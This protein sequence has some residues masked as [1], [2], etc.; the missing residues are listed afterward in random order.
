MEKLLEFIDDFSV[1][2]IMA[3]H[4]DCRSLGDIHSDFEHIADQAQQFGPDGQQEWATV[5][6]VCKAA[7]DLVEKTI[8]GEVDDVTA[9]MEAICQTVTSIKELI[10]CITQSQDGTAVSF[11]AELGI[12]APTTTPDNKSSDVSPDHDAFTDQAS[13][14]IQLPENVDED[15][16]K[17]FLANQP[18]VLETLESTILAAESDPSGDNCH[19]IKA[20]LHN[21]KGESGL[22][23]LEEMSSVCHEAESLLEDINGNFPGEGLFKAKDWLQNAVAV[24]T[25]SIFG[26][27]S[28]QAEQ[29]N[30]NTINT[31][32]DNNESEAPNTTPL[33]ESAGDGPVIAESDVPLVIDFVA[34]SN[35]HL[36]ATEAHL[37]SLEDDAGNKETINAIFRA[38]HTI[39]GVAGFLNLKEIG[40]LSHS[41][42]NLLDLARKDELE[43]TGGCI[44][45][46]FEASDATKQMLS[47]I[48][49]AVENHHPVKKQ[50]NLAEL[51]N[52][53]KTCASGEAPLSRLGQI[54]VENEVASRKNIRDALEQQQDDGRKIGEILIDQGTASADQIEKAFSTQKNASVSKVKKTQSTGSIKGNSEAT[55]KVT[56][57]RLDSL[58]NMVGELVIAQSMVSQDI[59][60][61]ATD[62]QRL[63]RNIRQ[64]DKATRDLQELSMS[65]RMVP[66]QGV[67]QKMARLVRDLSRKAGKQIE[68]VVTGAETELDRNVVEAI[69]DPLVHMIRNSIDHGIELPE[70]RQAVGKNPVGRVDLRAFHQAGN[71]CIE[72]ADDGKGLKREKILEKAIANG[73]VKEGQE[74]SD[75]EVY[76]LIFHAGLSTAEKVTDISGR[77]V[78]MD[79]V[80]KNIEVLRGRVDIDSTPGKG[81]TFNIKLPLTLAVIDGQSVTVGETSYI[82]PIISIEQSLR[83]QPE[84]IKTVQGGRG[85][86]IMIRGE[87]VPL[88]RLYEL[89]EVEPK[90]T[91]PCDSLVVVV[92]DGGMRCC[93]QIDQLLGQQQVVIKNLGQQLG[94]VQGVAGGAIMGDGNVSLILD[95]TGLIKL[96]TQN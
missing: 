12:K 69:A 42:E 39:K 75:Q 2:V 55:V 73:I 50:N 33:K 38:F 87:L 44:D 20:I 17:E 19:A 56:T 36:E 11:P 29:A 41:T 82:I 68:L 65:M 37:L 40:S 51:I 91:D 18:H 34:E 95:V 43:L 31:D 54:L 67:F 64:L 5:E 27:Q 70:E 26:N 72:I 90:Y 59:S 7:V 61:F 62:N 6:T 15:I 28:Q 22:M 8:L 48:L 49:V 24:L 83:P 79:V 14:N 25:N 45:V 78:G 74:L 60:S 46:V 13:Q 3:D 80:R 85:Q 58:I 16:F 89:F 53:I 94:S 66:V 84:Q 71:I 93:L 23:G 96:A 63:T 30:T 52:R 21:M 88:I 4:D 9:T 76:A 32:N 92:A 57:T 1:K 77:G 47:S 81:T 10:Q 35:E 86:M